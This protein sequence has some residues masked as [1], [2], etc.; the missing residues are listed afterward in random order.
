M[1]I[2][3]THSQGKLCWRL[4]NRLPGVVALGLVI[5]P[6]LLDMAPRHWSNTMTR[7]LSLAVSLR[8]VEHDCIYLVPF[9]NVKS[10]LVCSI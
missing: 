2:G 9:L 6:A 4:A 5:C 1:C 8:A 3:H 10:V 7:S